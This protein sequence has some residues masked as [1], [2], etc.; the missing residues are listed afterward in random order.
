MYKDNS[1]GGMIR[2]MNITKEG[3]KREL[4]TPKDFKYP[5]EDN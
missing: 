5:G 2:L 3:A 4:L 1:S